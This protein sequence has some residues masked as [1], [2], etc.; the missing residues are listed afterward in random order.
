MHFGGRGFVLEQYDLEFPRGYGF[1]HP[2]IE[3]DDSWLKGAELVAVEM[4]DAGSVTRR[5]ILDGFRMTP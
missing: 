3:L 1:D 4:V 2:A 5:V